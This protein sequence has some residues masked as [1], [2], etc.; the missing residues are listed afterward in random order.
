MSNYIYLAFYSKSEDPTER[1]FDMLQFVSNL[2]TGPFTHVQL[3]TGDLDGRGSVRCLN[4]TRKLVYVTYDMFV[5]DRPGYCYMKIPVSAI[6]HKKLIALCEDLKKANGQFSRLEFY[7]LRCG[8]HE[9]CSVKKKEWFCSEL[10]AWVLIEIG[11][12]PSSKC[13]PYQT[14]CTK[15]YLL[16]RTINNATQLEYNPF[17]TERTLVLAPDAIYTGYFG[18]SSRMIPEP[19]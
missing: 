7:G 8:C 11:L 2:F 5:M 17:F 13:D 18:I 6:Q 12:I 4:L 9:A 14:S 15:L 19:F 1:E 3:C 10:I 16:A